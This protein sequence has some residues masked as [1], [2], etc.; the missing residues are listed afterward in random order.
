MSAGVALTPNL[1][2]CSLGVL[3]DPSSA[4]WRSGDGCDPGGGGGRQLQPFRVNK[5]H[6]TVT[7]ALVISRLDYFNMLY[8]G[9][10]PWSWPRNYNWW[11][12]VLPV[13]YWITSVPLHNS[14]IPGVFW[15]QARCW[16]WSRS[17]GYLKDHFPIQKCLHGHYNHQRGTFSG[18]NPLKQ[19]DW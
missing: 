4:A 19:L 14:F 5:D 2:V 10:R 3:L 9:L 15:I 6:A 8:M 13:W 16:L 12:T 7:H 18:S 1:S 11:R 17:P